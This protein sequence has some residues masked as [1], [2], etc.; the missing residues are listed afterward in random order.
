MKKFV[1]TIGVIVALFFILRAVAEPFTIDVTDSASYR[2]DWGGPHLAGVLAVHCGPGI[3]AAV[4]LVLALVRRRQSRSVRTTASGRS[5][6][7]R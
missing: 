2:N 5:R 4:L 6:R 3:L 7:R 1:T